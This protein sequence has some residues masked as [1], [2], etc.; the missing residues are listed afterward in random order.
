MTKARACKG[1]NQEGSSGIKSYAPRNVGEC[2]GMNTH[3]PKW[4]PILGVGV[5]MDS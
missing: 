4:A 1:A 5:Q 2:E 3:I